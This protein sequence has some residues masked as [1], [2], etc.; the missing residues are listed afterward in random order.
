M[1]FI[2]Y[3]NASHFVNVPVSYCV[4][5]LFSKSKMHLEAYSSCLWFKK[6]DSKS[7][8]HRKVA[9]LSVCR[10]LQWMLCTEECA[11]T[12]QIVFL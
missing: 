10:V 12:P 9:V 11:V 1:V 5:D 4:M 7:L 6:H 2:L 3:D 8:V